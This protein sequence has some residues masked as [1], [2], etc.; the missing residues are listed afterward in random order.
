MWKLW[1][2]WNFWLHAFACASNCVLFHPPLVVIPLLTTEGKVRLLQTKRQNVL[3]RV[4]RDKSREECGLRWPRCRESRSTRNCMP[5]SRSKQLGLLSNSPTSSHR[6]SSLSVCCFV[7]FLLF[8]GL[9][10]IWARRIDFSP[11]SFPHFLLFKTPLP[12]HTPHSLNQYKY[13]LV[14]WVTIQARTTTMSHWA[15]PLYWHSS[16]FCCIL[17]CFFFICFYLI[18][19][20]V[21]PHCSQDLMQKGENTKRLRMH[22]LCPS[23]PVRLVPPPPH[24]DCL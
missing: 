7:S 6:L 9:S 16:F 8:R 19:M 14:H 18:C 12:S 22:F 4:S 24:R 17:F 3:T 15:Q 21:L 5:Q 20:P 13:L 2:C 1:V 10:A 23:W 11:P